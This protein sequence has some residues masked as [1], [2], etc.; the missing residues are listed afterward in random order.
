MKGGPFR[1][2][3][4]AARRVVTQTRAVIPAPR[5]WWARCPL[6]VRVVLAALLA[7]L[8]LPWVLRAYAWWWDRVWGLGAF[9]DTVAPRLP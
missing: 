6:A 8:M 4:S 1:W 9:L 2:S 7:L 3:G 5:L